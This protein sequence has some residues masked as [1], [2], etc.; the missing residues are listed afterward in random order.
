MV[1]IGRRMRNEVRILSVEDRDGW[2]A[3]HEDGGLPSQSWHYAH[4]LNASRIEPRLAV[5]CAKGARMLILFFE[6]EWRG[7]TDIATV[8]GLS[9]TSISPISSAPLS[10][11]REY[12]AAQGWVAGYI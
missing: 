5:V 7:R 2:E 9:G 8:P 4:A 3:E 10:L 12:A 6:R 11:W 1:T